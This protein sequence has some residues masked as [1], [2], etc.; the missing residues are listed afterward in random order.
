MDGI[1]FGAKKQTVPT[2]QKTDVMVS[3]SINQNLL[4]IPQDKISIRVKLPDSDSEPKIL[5]RLSRMMAGIKGAEFTYN[6]P[7]Q[8][9]QRKT[10]FTV[11][12]DNAHTL[13]Q[14]IQQNINKIEGRF[15]L[16][17]IDGDPRNVVV[18][19]VKK[20]PKLAKRARA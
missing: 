5:E 17:I 19:A 18:E 3:P 12:M 13:L 14:S 1:S 10:V 2:S 16:A 11:A 6:P 8:S 4:L 20:A 15:N 7:N 9:T